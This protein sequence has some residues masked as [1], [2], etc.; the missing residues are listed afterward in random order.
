MPN[1]TMTAPESPTKAPLESPTRAP[2]ESPSASPAGAPPLRVIAA[3]GTFDKRYDA[4]SGSL[5]F[6]A[7]CLPALCAEARLEPMPAFEVAMLL[8]SL[9]MT[10]AD[11]LAL[12]RCCAAAP[13]SRLVIVHGTDTMVETAAVLAREPALADRTIVLTG[14]M[15]PASVHGS[16]AP[17]NLGFA[18]AAARLAPA[19][20]WIA[21][22]GRLHAW[23]A[24]R[25]DRAAGRFVAG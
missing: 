9:V 7:S 23:D 15:V 11:R 3:G 19:G 18:V 10:E 6:G 8:D 20:T 12:A 1:R 24:V 4:V 14:A 13:E 21:M 25:K 16:D 22:H 5:G 17:F 2:T